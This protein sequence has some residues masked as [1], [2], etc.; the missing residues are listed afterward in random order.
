MYLFDGTPQKTVSYSS[1]PMCVLCLQMKVLASY[2]SICKLHPLQWTALAVFYD[3]I[4]LVASKAFDM[5]QC[6]H[7]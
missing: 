5:I 4:H 7:K 3:M 2:I 1:I 6:K